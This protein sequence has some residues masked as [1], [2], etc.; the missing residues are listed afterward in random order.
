MEDT[1]NQPSYQDLAHPI[2][3][4][5]GKNLKTK[6]QAPSAHLLI[7]QFLVIWRASINDQYLLPNRLWIDIGKEII[8]YSSYNG[9][10]S[11]YSALWKSCCLTSIAESFKLG[12]P[13][14]STTNVQYQIALLNNHANMTLRLGKTHPLFQLGLV[15]SQFYCSFKELWDAGKTYPF[16]DK[17]LEALCIDPG[18]RSLWA[19]ESRGITTNWNYDKV[20]KSYLKGKQRIAVALNAANTKKKSYGIREEHRMT[21]NMFHKLGQALISQHSI[22]QKD[23]IMDIAYQSIDSNTLL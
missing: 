20:L 18:L 3:L 15:Y 23:P 4:I 6:F 19:Q 9:V 14:L 11:S 1:L 8:P 16:Q 17:S 22:F 10:Q 21:W 5:S 2:L 7:Q 13:K 12:N